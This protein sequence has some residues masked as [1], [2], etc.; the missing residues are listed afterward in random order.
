MALLLA[1]AALGALTAPPSLTRADELPPVERLSYLDQAQRAYDDL[2]YEDARSLLELAW[3]SGANGP[4]ELRLLF[5]LHGEVAITLG[6]VAAGEFSFRRLL[7]LDPRAR[8]PEGTSPKIVQ[9]LDAAREVLGGRTL[10]VRHEIVPGTGI[11][12]IVESDPLAMIAGARASYR[13]SD[14][15]GERRTLEA[16]GRDRIELPLPAGELEVVVAAVDEHGNRLVELGPLRVAP[17]APATASGGGGSAERPVTGGAR[18]TPLWR[19]WAAWGTL[20]AGFVG[21]GVV[22]GLRA[23]DAQAELDRLNADSRNHPFTDA[24]EVERRLH[25]DV[26]LAN[27]SFGAA[28]V[29]GVVTGVLVWRALR[30]DDGRGGREPAVRA[31]ILPGGAALDVA[32]RF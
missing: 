20:T 11:A 8:L 13:P 17:R 2:R 18:A 4:A 23:R 28:A 15:D 25:R 30:A 7:A 21:G 10:R 16:T 1:L 22:F 14:G 27:V 19:H 9:W 3:R 24:Q 12:L 31:A 26:L 29:C 6:D 5:R 32:V